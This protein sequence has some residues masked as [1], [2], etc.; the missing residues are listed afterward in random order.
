M[1][2]ERA[3]WVAFLRGMNVGGHR[4]TMDRL[5]AHFEALGLADPTT[6]LASGNVAFLAPAGDAA[7][8]ERRIEAHL[9]EALGYAVDTF[10]RTPAELAA[11]VGAG[12]F[13]PADVAAPGHSVQV[14]FLREAMR[15]AEAAR[16][17][18]FD[19]DRD[20][21]RVRGRELFW[22]CRGRMSDTTVDWKTLEKT[23]PM[24]STIRNLNTVRKIAAKYPAGPA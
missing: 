2:A 24:R 6:F 17:A 14:G 23:V 15:A 20:L 4:I 10:V 12:V 1:T 3:R 13:D 7:A 19:T 22:L 11:V 8:L 9:R 16:V 18:E 5:R 21:L